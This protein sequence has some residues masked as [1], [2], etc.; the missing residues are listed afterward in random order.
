MLLVSAKCRAVTPQWEA[1]ADGSRIICFGNYVSTLS[2]QRALLLVAVWCI[3]HSKQELTAAGKSEGG[4]E[5]GKSSKS[6]VEIVE[7]K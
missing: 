2:P 7:L 1:K 4:T 3:G 5:V 6:I